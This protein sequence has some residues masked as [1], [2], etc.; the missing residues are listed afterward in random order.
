[1]AAAC[2]GLLFGMTTKA[3]C[4]LY[5]AVQ[6]AG[7]GNETGIV[8][9]NNTDYSTGQFSA[10]GNTSATVTESGNQVLGPSAYAI[11]PVADSPSAESLWRSPSYL[12]TTVPAA[13]LA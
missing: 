13:I 1:M 5:V 8:A 7:N 11:F 12:L 3:E 2:F 4:P 9:E 6:F 10:S